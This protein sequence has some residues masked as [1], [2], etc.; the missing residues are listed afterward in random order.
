MLTGVRAVVARVEIQHV[1]DRAAEREQP[2]RFGPRGDVLRGHPRYRRDHR[3]FQ[4]ADSEPLSHRDFAVFRGEPAAAQHVA[5]KIVDRVH[6][7]ALAFAV[8]IQVAVFGRDAALELLE[9]HGVAGSGF[10]DVDIPGL[11]GGGRKIRTGDHGQKRGEVGDGLTLQRRRGGGS[12]DLK[13]GLAPVGEYDLRARSCGA[14]CQRRE[15][16]GGAYASERF[17]KHVPLRSSLCIHPKMVI[18][19]RRIP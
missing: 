4:F 12:D 6:V 11:A 13:G 14:E 19:Y 9:R 3:P 16:Y 15:Q 8:K 2:L 17:F 18:I 5:Q 1:H 7:A 10:A